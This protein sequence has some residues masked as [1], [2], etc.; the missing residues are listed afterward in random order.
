MGNLNQYYHKASII[1]SQENNIY[2]YEKVHQ[3]CGGRIPYLKN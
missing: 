2:Y 3:I 1:Y